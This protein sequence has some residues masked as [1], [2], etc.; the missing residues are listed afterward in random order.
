MQITAIKEPKTGLEGKFSVYHAAR[1]VAAC[2]HPQSEERRF[3][4]ED[5]KP[6][7]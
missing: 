1:H 7:S 4:I 6:H 5:P 2:S 3:G